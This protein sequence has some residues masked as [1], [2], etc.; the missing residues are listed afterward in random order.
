MSTPRVRFLSCG[1]F[2]CIALALQEKRSGRGCNA[3][4]SQ[5]QY[6]GRMCRHPVSHM[7]CCKV[8]PRAPPRDA[9]DLVAWPYGR[10]CFPSRIKEPPVWYHCLV[11][12]SNASQESNRY[13][14]KM[15]TSAELKQFAFAL[16]C[17]SALLFH[18]PLSPLLYA[19]LHTTKDIDPDKKSHKRKRKEVHESTMYALCSNVYRSNARTSSLLT[20]APL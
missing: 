12:A 9:E 18:A 19:S 17:R 15:V 14:S 5:K 20:L 1:C 4:G 7:T 10:E 3:N 16:L 8:I 13:V 6:S 2:G 11:V